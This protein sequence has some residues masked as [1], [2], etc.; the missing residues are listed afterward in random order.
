[1]ECWD[2]CAGF[3]IKKYIADPPTK[4]NQKPKWTPK[5]FLNRLVKLRIASHKSV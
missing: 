4:Y 5:E 2:V 1:M 3:S